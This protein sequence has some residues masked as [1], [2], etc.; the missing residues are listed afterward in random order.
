MKDN[1]NPEHL[2]A[3]D[4]AA[5]A[6]VELRSRP[7]PQNVAGQSAPVDEKQFVKGCIS[8]YMGDRGPGGSS[9]AAKFYTMGS[10]VDKVMVLSYQIALRE[11]RDRRAQ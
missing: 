7:S 9:A 8:L 5:N 3:V 2:E 11:Q 4:Y 10:L 6:L 1:P